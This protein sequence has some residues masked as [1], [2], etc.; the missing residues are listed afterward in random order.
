MLF[1]AEL[2]FSIQNEKEYEFT[3]DFSKISYRLKKAMTLRVVH[4]LVKGFCR[5]APPVTFAQMMEALKIP[6]SLLQQILAETQAAG[7][8]SEICPHEGRIRAYQPARDVDLL[9]VKYVVD[10]LEQQGINHISDLSGPDFEK[11]KDSLD[12]LDRFFGKGF[13]KCAVE[14]DLIFLIRG[15]LGNG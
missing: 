13:G 5:G 15:S 14:R 2:I 4:F 10:Q 11:I 8:V 7:I 1:G 9:T 12:G 6:K 3:P